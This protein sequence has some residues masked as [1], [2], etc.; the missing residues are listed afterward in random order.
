M[1]ES[2]AHNESLPNIAFKEWAVVC[3]ALASRQQ[4]IIL[5]KGGIVEPGGQF[6]LEAEEFLLL[7]TFLH[8]S[9]ESLTPGARPLLTTIE[10]DRPPAGTVVFHH[11]VKITDAFVVTKNSELSG[12]RQRHIWSDRIVQ[13]RF[14]RWEE[15]LDVLVVAVSPL[16]QPLQLPWHESYDGCKSWV[17]LVNHTGAA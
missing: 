4:D 12:L 3:R 16:S 17:H 8:Q 5:R 9:A 11:R 10:D 1:V 15:R 6:R 7:P 13:E 2:S 14:T